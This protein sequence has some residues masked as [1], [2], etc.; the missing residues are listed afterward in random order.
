MVKFKLKLKTVIPIFTVILLLVAGGCGPGN[1]K[2]EAKI[3]TGFAQGTTYRI[4]IKGDTVVG[5]KAAIDSLFDVVDRSLSLY[6]PNSLISRINRNETDSVDALIADCIKVAHGISET[7]GGLYDITIKPLTQAYGFAEGKPTKS[8]NLDSLLPIIG[9]KKISVQ[10]G[11]L[12]K[13]DPRM[14]LDLNSIAQGATSDIIS[15]YLDSQGIKEY[16]V[17][18]GGGEIYCKGLNANGEPWRVGIDRPYEGNIVPGQD[19]QTV[20][21]VSDKGL[22][23]SGNYRKFYINEDG[24]KVVHTVNPITGKC[25]ISNL[26]SATVVAENATLA[27]AYGTM[28]MV[29][30]LNESIK[31]LEG[32]PELDAYLIYTDDDG[33]YQIYMTPGMS[34]MVAK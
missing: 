5:T 9:Y 4:A 21:G 11:R 7:S 30:G 20:I 27:D 22:A 8:P 16:L 14:Q 32:H 6:N 13:S 18:T 2:E 24:D 15:R 25:V 26:L 19:L 10:N 28:F 29:L 12:V 17:V 23:T 33:V 31:F 1:K 3:I 34:E